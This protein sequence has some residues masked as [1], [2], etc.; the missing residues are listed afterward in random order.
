MIAASPAVSGQSGRR[1]RTGFALAARAGLA[2]A[3]LLALGWAVSL[4]RTASLLVAVELPTVFGALALFGAS[5]VLSAWRWRFGLR[6]MVA[7][8]PRLVSLLRLILLGIACNAFVPTTV[9]GDVTRAEVL[10]RVSG[11][12]PAY[13]SIMV[14]RLLGLTAVVSLGS[15]A[16]GLAWWR[17]LVEGR[18]LLVPAA[19]V[20]LILVVV[21]LH[22]VVR[23]AGRTMGRLQPLLEALGA[24]TRRPMVPAVS[25]AVAILVQLVGAIAPLMLI[26]RD[27]GIA[28]GWQ[29][30]LAVIPAVIL[31]TLAPVTINGI[32]V[33]EG[34]LVILY[35]Q[36]GVAAD[37][38][39]AL[40]IAW[41]LMITA[42]AV[43]GGLWWLLGTSRLSTTP[44]D[45]RAVRP[46]PAG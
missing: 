28:V 37:P 33:R 22:R 39:F 46:P 16:L 32:G 13:A 34:A 21:V 8:P 30:H 14:D 41:T 38:A 35:G 44:A 5:L 36:A 26:A 15:L 7:R 2:L 45:A 6:R 10:Q 24:F 19:A 9:A 17:G 25:F 1:A 20:G 43:L 42:F 18:L 3:C 4:E 23:Q 27:L 31:L 29:V 12:G 40:G 11:R